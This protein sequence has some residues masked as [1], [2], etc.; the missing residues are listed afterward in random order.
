MPPKG[1]RRLNKGVKA[2]KKKADK[3][4]ADK[5]KARAAAHE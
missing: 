4:L 1:K 5:K 2:W 3:K